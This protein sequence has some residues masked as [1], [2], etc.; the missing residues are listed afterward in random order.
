MKT[1]VFTLCSACSAL[2]FL[3]SC[4][5]FQVI[6]GDGDLVTEE[7]SI[8]DYS[9]IQTANSSTIDITYTQSDGAAGL[10]LVT[11]R[12]IYDKYDIRVVED[13]LKI[14][15]KKEYEHALFKPTSFI[16]TTNSAHLRKIDI[17]G[18]ASFTVNNPLH[19]DELDIDLAG[20]GKINLNDTLTAERID[21]DI[22]GSGTLNAPAIEGKSF[23]GDI[24]GSGRLNLGGHLTSASFDI[25]GS[26]TIRAFDLQVE[27]MECDI[28]GSGDIEISVTN[29]IRADVA[30]SGRIKYKGEPQHIQK[31]ILGGGSIRKVD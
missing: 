23:D 2:L 3:N 27:D 13:E 17:A 28:A 9:G 19:T 29:S 22:A 18:S 5:S 4:F 6:Q 16:V 30:G 21:I 15:P 1:K 11:D 31:D 10:S 25:A 7:I 12:N 14:R 24:A 8:S 26:G 20:S